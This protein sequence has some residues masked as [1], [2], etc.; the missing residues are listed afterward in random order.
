MTNSLVATTVINIVYFYV[1]TLLLKERG[2]NS[3]L[4]ILCYNQYITFFLVADNA[5]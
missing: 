1:L 5:H 2:K 4:L 3:I